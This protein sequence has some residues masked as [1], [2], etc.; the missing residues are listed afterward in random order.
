MLKR[1]AILYVHMFYLGNRLIDY[2]YLINGYSRILCLYFIF[3]NFILLRFNFYKSVIFQFKR[4]PP[5][6][7]ITMPISVSERRGAIYYIILSMLLIAYLSV[8]CTVVT[9][10]VNHTYIYIFTYDIN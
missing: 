5:W 3:F 2:P 9:G 7:I 6:I 1:L 8:P 10:Y 4:N